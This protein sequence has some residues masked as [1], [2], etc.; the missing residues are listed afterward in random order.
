MANTQD[1]QNILCLLYLF[2]L[3]RF[4]CSKHI[5]KASGFHI[6]TVKLLSPTYIS[7]AN[8]KMWCFV[9]QF[10]STYQA[11]M[12][13]SYVWNIFLFGVL[14]FT[15]HSTPKH[16]TF[17]VVPTLLFYDYIF[18]VVLVTENYKRK[19]KNRFTSNPSLK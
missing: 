16:C 5:L 14:G 8:K 18:T 9:K 17:Y 12:C 15:L 2:E 6:I 10:I 11:Q 4:P 19:K 13:V 7:L 1:L 3:Q